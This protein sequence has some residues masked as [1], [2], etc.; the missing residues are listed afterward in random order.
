[1]PGPYIPFYQFTV[2]IV[3]LAALI[4]CLWELPT[5]LRW[6]PVSIADHLVLFHHSNFLAEF[7]GMETSSRDRLYERFRSGRF[8]LGYW[9]RGSLGVWHG[10]GKVKNGLHGMTSDPAI[11]SHLTVA[12]VSLESIQMNDFNS[13]PNS[14][15]NVP[16]IAISQGDQAPQLAYESG[17]GRAGTQTTSKCIY[18]STTIYLIY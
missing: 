1:M 17:N 3:G 2:L 11:A 6:D 9:Q 18:C 13:N 10:F 8:R 16:I 7:E 14:I 12:E 15:A 5:G 4:Y